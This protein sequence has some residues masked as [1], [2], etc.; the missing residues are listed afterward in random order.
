[1]EEDLVT[2]AYGSLQSHIQTHI[3]NIIGDQ[4]ALETVP[5]ET[6]LHWV[7]EFLPPPQDEFDILQECE[8]LAQDGTRLSRK[9]HIFDSLFAKSKKG[10]P[11]HIKMNFLLK[12]IQRYSADLLRLCKF[13]ARG[14]TYEDYHA[15]RDNA[16]NQ[17]RLREQLDGVDRP[18]RQFGVR[19]TSQPPSNKGTGGQPKRQDAKDNRPP[20]EKKHSRGSGKGGDKDGKGGGK[21]KRPRATLVG[22]DPAYIRQVRARLGDVCL[23]CWQPGH[24]VD[25]FVPVYWRVLA[26]LWMSFPYPHVKDHRGATR[27]R[28]QKGA[29][30]AVRR[31]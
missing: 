7:R 9:Y 5:L 14:L 11:D 30:E 26:K 27:S 15:F 19:P 12:A 6:L 22:M 16:F 25:V 29:N 17:T 1:M 28:T 4:R 13:D 21:G 31:R 8:D 23:T 20:R 2:L 3:L 10:L 18:R 24:Y